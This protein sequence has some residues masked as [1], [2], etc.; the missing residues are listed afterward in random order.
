[1]A[2][3]T[4]EAR[5]VNSESPLSA[6]DD[7]LVIKQ[8]IARVEFNGALWQA[9]HETYHPD[10]EAVLWRGHVDPALVQADGNLV[11]VYLHSGQCLQLFQGWLLMTD[12]PIEY[13]PEE[14]FVPEP[15]TIALLGGGLVGLAG[16]AALRLRWGT[17]Q[18]RKP[19]E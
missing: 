17:S 2:R 14:E 8:Q 15:A 12:W 19:R 16:Y 3:E 1:M 9:E 6:L 5:Y 11:Q 7:Q 10:D 13:E 4:L 18:A